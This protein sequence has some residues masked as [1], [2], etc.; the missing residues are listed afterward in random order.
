[1]GIVLWIFAVLLGGCASQIAVDKEPWSVAAA[2]H[3]RA[4]LDR[5]RE[6]VAVDEGLLTRFYLKRDD[7]PAWCGPTGPKSQADALL[8]ML[9]QVNSFY[10]IST[11]LSNLFLSTV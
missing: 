8:L 7:R 11:S 9:Q 5:D 6:V 1:M 3:L 10:N 4:Q 2:A